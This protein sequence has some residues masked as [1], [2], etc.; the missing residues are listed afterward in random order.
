[1]LADVL[2][3]LILIEDSVVEHAMETSKQ[4][5]LKMRTSNAKIRSIQ[6]LSNN[7]RKL[8]LVELLPT[9]LCHTAFPFSMFQVVLSYPGK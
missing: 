1:M 2:V 7:Q 6:A 4:K 9:I 8:T 5:K 3:C